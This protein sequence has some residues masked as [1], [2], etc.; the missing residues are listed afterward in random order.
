MTYINHYPG[1]TLLSGCQVVTDQG[2]DNTVYGSTRVQAPTAL[3][4][5]P[6][7]VSTLLFNML[8]PSLLEYPSLFSFYYFKY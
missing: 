1:G 3:A 8:G 7:L 4:E 2:F 6:R 5:A